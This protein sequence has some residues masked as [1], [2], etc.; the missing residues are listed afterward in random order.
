MPRTKSF[1]YSL[2]HTHTT[3]TT[4]KNGV[5]I[6][7]PRNSFMFTGTSFFTLFRFSDSL[8][9]WNVLVYVCVCI[10]LV[11][12]RAF[13]FD[14]WSYQS[15]QF[16]CNVSN[17]MLLSQLVFAT[18]ALKLWQMWVMIWG[19]LLSIV[20]YRLRVQHFNLVVIL[21]FIF[22][23]FGSFRESMVFVVW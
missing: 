10:C 1:Q 16:I 3:L 18:C 19:S 9:V 14:T 17:E 15:V 6:G 8:D 4:N 5:G 2:T 11:F 12:I 22:C 7:Q 21:V 13:F 20:I 23:L